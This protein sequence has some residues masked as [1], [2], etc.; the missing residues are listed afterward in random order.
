MS[1]QPGL[2]LADLAAQTKDVEVPGG[3]VTV[4]GISVQTALALLQRYPHL[5]KLANGFK[6]S[7]LIVV[8]PGALAAI[9]AAGFGKFGD[10]QA[11]EQAADIPIETQFDLIEAIGGLTF[12][13]GFGPFVSRV[14]ALADA[15]KSAPSTKAFS[16][17]LPQTSKPSL[18]ADTDPAMSGDTPQDK[19]APTASSPTGE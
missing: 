7:D 11:E 13:N 19:S 9:I 18:P 16:T 5:A 17:S 6:V 10:E 12:K 15:V 1:K 14:M 2:N 4:K 8:A 3:F